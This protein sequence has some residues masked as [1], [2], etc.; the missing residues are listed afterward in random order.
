MR[1]QAIYRIAWWLA[2]AS[3][4]VWCLSFLL[5]PFLPLPAPQRALAA[6]SFVGLG[7]GMFWVAVAIGGPALLVAFRGPRIR[8]GESFSGRTAVVIGATGG[9]GRAISAALLREGALVVAVGRRPEAIQPL[10]EA[11]GARAEVASLDSGEQDALA[12][13]TGEVDCVIF[14]AGIDVRKPLAEHTDADVDMQLSVG[15]RGPISAVRAWLPR[16]REG[17]SVVL[18]G[19]FGDGRLA[20]PYYSVDVAARAGL[21]AFA[22]SVTRELALSGRDV[23]VVY[24]CPAPA[25]TEAERPFADLWASMGTAMVSPERVADFVLSAAISRPSY[26][27]M[28]LGNRLATALERLSSSLAERLV[29]GCLGPPLRA[30]FGRERASQGTAST[31]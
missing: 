11:L 3:V 30:R 26:A 17:G 9:L 22:A 13:R 2:L 1:S 23:R 28:G 21:A 14:A 12:A 18:V 6:A 25:D 29:V 24:A 20:L 31:G 8:T 10:A 5:A 4:P 15:L 7:E 19:G 27:I 16:V